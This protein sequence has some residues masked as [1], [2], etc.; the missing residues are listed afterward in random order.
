MK[1]QDTHKTQ[2][3][4]RS[5]AATPS[6]G[7]GG[8]KNTHNKRSIRYS[9]EVKIAAVKMYL[10]EG[11]PI[12]VIVAETGA[13]DGTLYTWIKRYKD[14]GEEG[15]KSNYAYKEKRRK[16]Q[17]STARALRET[18]VSMKKEN[19]SWGVKRIAQEMFYKWLKVS[20]ETVRK[21][22]H[23]ENLIEPPKKKRKK[24]EVKPRFFERSTPNQMWQTDIMMFPLGGK[25]A[26]LIGYIDDYS[27]FLVGLDLFRS[28]TAENVIELYRRSIGEYGLPREMLTDNGRQ[29]TNW[30]GKSRFE[31]ELGKDGVK[32]F[33]SQPHHPMTLGKIERFWQTILTDFINRAQFDSFEQARER[34]RLWVKYYN[35]QRPHQGIDGVRPAD[36]FFEVATELRKVIER[37]IEENTLELALRGK[38][39]TPFYMVGRLNGEN[40][41]MQAE[42]GK[43]TMQV[44]K[45][46]ELEPTTELSYDI[47][48]ETGDHHAIKD[49]EQ[50]QALIDHH[51]RKGEAVLN[52]PDSHER[53]RGNASASVPPEA[54]PPLQRQ[55]ES[56][57]GAVAMERTPQYSGDLPGVGYHLH[58]ASELAGDGTERYVGETGTP[59]EGRGDE[60]GFEYKTGEASCEEDS[61]V[62]LREWDKVPLRRTA[63]APEF[64]SRED[65][66]D[67]PSIVQAAEDHYDG[68]RERQNSRATG[69]GYPESPDGA[70]DSH[71]RR[72]RVEGVPQD[73]LRMAGEGS[74]GDVE[75]VEEQR[76][77]ASRGRGGYRVERPEERSGD[78]E[79][80]ERATDD[81]DEGAGYP[82]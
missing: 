63:E 29:Y 62:P 4:E 21:T 37:G 64:R 61:Y 44:N 54:V 36:R 18:A 81:E 31:K 10:E 1:Y 68:E 75:R 14:H 49:Q 34:V 46:N 48:P 71:R 26:Y 53:K 9:F 24:N 50:V 22:L 3:S 77:W 6:S 56:D 82:F 65:E 80:R 27:R 57:S 25:N 2:A 52:V 45:G 38:P 35:H 43:L 79:R 51:Q 42:K 58:D 47:N 74:D 8:Q 23:E 17:T 28:Q 41:V 19:R 16:Q 78:V 32:H 76:R 12:D 59:G 39:R 40:V 11:F 15:L 66:L 33:K 7:G 55:R 20:P 60:A 69:G 70:D 72:R 30:R 13:S 5:S 73:F 67:N